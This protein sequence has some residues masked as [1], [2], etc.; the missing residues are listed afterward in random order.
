[1]NSL[2]KKHPLNRLILSAMCSFKLTMHVVIKSKL[3]ITLQECLM[4]YAPTVGDPN[5]ICGRL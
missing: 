2:G 5:D 4:M 1:M 3:P